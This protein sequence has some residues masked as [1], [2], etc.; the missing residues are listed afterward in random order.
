MKEIEL[1]KRDQE[2][3]SA[4]VR[5]YIET[6]EPVGSRAVARR[7][8]E[9]L[10]AA[11]IRNVM[12]ELEDRDLLMQPHASAGRVPT[13]LAYR[14][15]V[16]SLMKASKLPAAQE[17]LIAS[18]LGDTSNGSQDLF[19]NVS[20][21]LSRFSKH[22]GVVVSP[23]IARVRLRDVEF[24]RLA[25][26]RVLVILVAASGMIHNKIVEIPEDHDQEKLD[27]IG[28]YLTDEFKGETVPEI[29]DRILELM[30]Q[31][32]AL[33]DSLLRDALSLGDRSLRIG[34]E[35]AVPGG[36]VFVDGAVNLMSEP[37]FTSI[38]RLKALFRAFEEK[39]ELL[40]VLNSCLED[41]LAGVRV[42]IG[43]E[44]PSPIMSEC[45]LVASNYGADGQTLGT[46]GIIGPTRMEYARAI[47]L[48]DSVAK[49]FSH[50][51]ARYPG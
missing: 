45:A 27:R 42:V 39:H 31:E 40:L 36:D 44:N 24:V 15:Y 17:R 37:E 5:A 50:A 6:G 19:A 46:L 28:R 23:H 20:R 49:L 51:L 3:L 11:T 16:D 47:A 4:V 7:N 38:E 14:V 2:I 35:T 9:G 26:H 25:P 10:S 43:S 29:R 41:Q 34:S 22:L 48:V 33:Y 18:S 30:G 12:A 1:S 32:K 13:D 21:I 8:A